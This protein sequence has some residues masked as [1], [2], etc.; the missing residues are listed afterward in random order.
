MRSRA[1]RA[2]DFVSPLTEV[3]RAVARECPWGLQQ[4]A[5]RFVELSG[6]GP[7]AALTAAFGLVLDAQ[8]LGEPA[9][10]VTPPH[11]TF[12]PPDVAEAGVD[13]SA[14]AVV[15][16]PD[17]L[18]AA[19]SALQL[20]RSGAFG[21]VVV[22]FGMKNQDGRATRIPAPLQTRLV[23]LAQKH[24][25]AVVVLVEKTPERQSLGSLISLRADVSR[26]QVNLSSLAPHPAVALYEVKLHIIKDKRRGPGRVHREVCH[27]PS[28]LC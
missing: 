17:G 7:T 27:G 28:G 4:I 11:S 16:A 12:Y 22:D 1:L 14:L 8:H 2:S 15:R 3:H 10:W 6:T 19:R 20:T 23:G 5:G 9:A 25:T 24:D 18:A 21:L 26:E 13:L